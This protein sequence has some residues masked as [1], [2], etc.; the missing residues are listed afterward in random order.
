MKRIYR[1]AFGT[2]MALM[3]LLAG[4]CGASQSTSSTDNTLDPSD[5]MIARE[6]GSIGR[7]DVSDTDRAGYTTFEDFVASRTAGVDVDEFGRLVIRGR[8]TDK[9]YT[10]PLIIYDGVEVYDTRMINPYD[11]ATVEVIKDGTASIYGMRGNG[12]VIVVTSKAKAD[13]A[14]EQTDGDK[15]VQ[16]EVNSK[17]TKRK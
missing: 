11:I 17:V 8:S 2:G 10:P 1:L 9:G 13:R 3:L 7:I 14:K 4:G 6:T 5:A 15:S 16:V 12:G